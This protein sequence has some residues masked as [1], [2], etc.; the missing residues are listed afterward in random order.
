VPKNP[1]AEYEE[2]RQSVDAHQNDINGNQ[3]D[4]P[5]KAAE[6]M[7]KIAGEANPP[8]HLF[9]GNDAYE[10]AKAKIADVQ[11]DMQSR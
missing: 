9:L 7:I 4:D 10:M 5:E 3:P 1:I 11:K 2:A 6:V 8:L